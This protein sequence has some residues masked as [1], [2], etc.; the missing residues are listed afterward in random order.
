M[1]SKVFVITDATS[2]IGKALAM[3]LA[4]TGEVVV[5]VARDVERGNA[6][7]QEI[8]LGTQNFNVSLE[9]CDLSVLS[10]VRNLSEI[11]KSK[12]QKIDVLVNSTSLYKRK[13]GVTVDGFEKTFAANYLSPFLLTNLLIESLQ[14]AVQANGSARVLNITAPSLAQIDFEDLQSERNFNSVK[15]FETAQMANLLFTFALARRLESTGITVNA[16]HPGSA[17]RTKVFAPLRLFGWLRPQTADNGLE[18]L[19][20]AA[21]A[22]EFE[23]MTGKFLHNG[24]EIEAPAYAYDQNAQQRLWEI[25][26]SLTQLTSTKGGLPI[27]DPHLEHDGVDRGQSHYN[28]QSVR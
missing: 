13:R 2:T 27:N 1:G 11:L 6:V 3:D 22:P 5:M 26:E 8:R 9:L 23:K 24:K 19:V 16:I 14:L 25:S 7:L 21:I 4:K 15:A 18:P 10:S 20:R 12:C 17:T 28:L